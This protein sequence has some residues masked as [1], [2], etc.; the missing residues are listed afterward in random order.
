MVRFPAPG[1]GFDEIA[2]RRRGC[3][4]SS[5]ET[6]NHWFTHEAQQIMS[7]IWEQDDD[8]M[9]GTPCSPRLSQSSPAFMETCTSLLSPI[10]KLPPELLG[11]IFWFT[12]PTADYVYMRKDSSPLLIS[13]VCQFWREVALSTPELWSSISLGADDSQTLDG[14]W[15]H[16]YAVRTWLGRSGKYSLSIKVTN[17][18]TRAAAYLP[19]IQSFAQRLEDLYLQTFPGATLHELFSNERIYP[20]LKRLAIHTAY[21]RQAFEGDLDVKACAPL[22]ESFKAIVIFPPRFVPIR[23]AWTQITE[24]RLCAMVTADCMLRLLRQCPQLVCMHILVFPM[25]ETCQG[26]HVTHE[27]LN[28]LI[29]G[30]DNPCD[31]PFEFMTLPAL[32]T[33]KIEFSLNRRRE[34]LHMSS[35]SRFQMSKFVDMAVRSHCVLQTLVLSGICVTANEWQR[36]FKLLPLLRKLTVVEYKYSDGFSTDGVLQVLACPEEG[37][38]LVPRL[39]TLSL[40]GCSSWA[41]NLAAMLFQRRSLVHLAGLDAEEQE[42]ERNGLT[43]ASHVDPLEHAYI[44]FRKRMDDQHARDKLWELLGNGR[45]VETEVPRSSLWY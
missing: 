19:V 20:R 30:G 28:E 34:G 15:P 12:L 2:S 42:Q 7:H 43:G 38:E 3:V 17:Y 36:C 31:V 41:K 29:I 18:R 6:K 40:I 5:D 9:S 33:A 1:G 32:H 8:L 44:Y 25:R 39:Q 35:S 21:S 22:L 14:N 26:P 37:Y 27:G 10:W 23:V 24:F 4:I 45:R 11:R 13:Q 16:P